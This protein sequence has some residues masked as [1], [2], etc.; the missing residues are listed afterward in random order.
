MEEEDTPLPQ[1]T[2]NKTEIRDL[3][4]TE[5]KILVMKMLT[6]LRRRMNKHTRTSKMS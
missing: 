2:L 5:F 3:S 1:K 4:D 6:E